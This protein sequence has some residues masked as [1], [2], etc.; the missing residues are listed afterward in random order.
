[1][2]FLLSLPIIIYIALYCFADDSPS[3][4]IFQLEGMHIGE[5][6]EYQIAEND[7]NILRGNTSFSFVLEK[8]AHQTMMFLSLRTKIHVYFRG[9]NISLD[10]D[11]MTKVRGWLEKDYYPR[12]FDPSQDILYQMLIGG[13]WGDAP[14]YRECLERN[15]V[16]REDGHKYNLART[17]NLL[18]IA[19]E[20]GDPKAVDYFVGEIGIDPNLTNCNGQNALNI[21]AT[22]AHWPFVY[23]LLD[24]GL[25]TEE[26][27]NSVSTLAASIITINNAHTVYDAMSKFAPNM[28]YDLLP[29]SNTEILHDLMK[30]G[31]KAHRHIMNEIMCLAPK[32]TTDDRDGGWRVENDA[33][34]VDASNEYSIVSGRDMACRALMTQLEYRCRVF[35][36][37]CE[38]IKELE[39]KVN[40]LNLLNFKWSD[41]RD[42]EKI[43]DKTIF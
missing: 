30:R 1:M 14:R 34:L 5:G 31:A 27:L 25:I 35:K 38:K 19:A 6:I 3:L 13:D 36:F 15:G 16:I 8:E 29:M 12:G 20:F 26:T 33:H 4:S 21:A 10:P 37:E 22:K 24:T 9:R 18:M 41:F 28:N 7:L 2:K 42:P 11:Y 43:E 17:E 39:K 32:T 40:H 23:R